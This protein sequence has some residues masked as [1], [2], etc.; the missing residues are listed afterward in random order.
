VDGYDLAVGGG[1]AAACEPCFRAVGLDP[2]VALALAIALG[3]FIQVLRV[4][5]PLALAR[6]KAAPEPQCP[7]P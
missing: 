4:V 1:T 2:G 6:R 5:I 3:V 7:S